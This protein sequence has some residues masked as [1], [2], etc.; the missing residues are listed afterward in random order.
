MP[1]TLLL[2]SGMLLGCT[3][4]SDTIAGDTG[5]TAPPDTDTTDTRGPREVWSAPDL[6][7]L[8]VTTVAADQVG[9]VMSVTWTQDAVPG[10]P[11]EDTLPGVIVE[12][13]V[14]DGVWMQ[15]PPQDIAV[16][17]AAS[18]WM[19][20]LPFDAD[21]TYRIRLDDSLTSDDH[22]SWTEPTPDGLPAAEVLQADAG[23]WEPEGQFLI[24][25]VNQ[26][27][28]GW[29]SGT[30]WKVILD[31][32]GRPVWAMQTPLGR[33]SIFARISRDGD[34]LLYDESSY[35]SDFD[36]GQGSVVHRM[37]IDGSVVETVSTPGLHHAYVELAD[38]GLAWGAADWVTEDLVQRTPGGPVE[39]IW[40]C[41]DYHDS[42]DLEDHCQSNTLFWQEETDSFWMS[43]YTSSS[44]VEID[45]QTGETLRYF[46]QVGG[47]WSFI[48]EDAMIAWQHGVHITDAGTLLLS[49]HTVSGELETVAREYTLDNKAQTLTQIWSFGV[50]EGVHASTAGEAHRLP[51]GN[52]LHNYG[53]DGRFREVTSDGEIVWEV[54]FPH[55]GEQRLVGRSIFTDSLYHFVP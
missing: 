52:T 22:A 13:S 33:W 1:G 36:A 34:D 17:E 29:S 19:L 42:L 8:D 11:G 38:G 16:G 20:G 41:G 24:T 43:F 25:S 46:G 55:G 40:E 14:D 32:Q 30:Y 47:P 37:K 7:L 53:S 27:T 23:R 9:S 50:G 2:I 51:G 45:H 18:V 10:K 48:P 12:F 49:T 21:F 4:N 3:G 39:V 54:Q 31:R 28:G 35:W 5:D 15:A 26:D 44:V 6:G